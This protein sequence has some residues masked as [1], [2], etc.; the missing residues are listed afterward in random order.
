MDTSA[1]KSLTTTKMVAQFYIDMSKY[2]LVLL[3]AYG[4]FHESQQTAIVRLFLIIVA[5]AAI[6]S[7]GLR[8]ERAMDRIDRQE[9]KTHESEQDQ[10]M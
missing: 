1:R 7:A 9:K 10:G 8:A 2:L 5:L 3:F 6:V 4:L